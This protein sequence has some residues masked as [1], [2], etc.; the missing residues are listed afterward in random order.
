M[1]KPT[2]VP[3]RKKS[4]DCLPLSKAQDYLMGCQDLNVSKFANFLKTFF[5]YIKKLH[6]GYFVNMKQQQNRLKMPIL[7]YCAKSFEKICFAPYD[8]MSV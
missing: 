8:P 6:A 7:L 5:T 3:E 4:F 1:N 2:I